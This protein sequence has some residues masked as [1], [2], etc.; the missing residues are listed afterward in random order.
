MK[1]TQHGTDHW[2]FGTFTVLYGHPV[3]PVPDALTPQRKPH[4]RERP[5]LHPPAPGDLWP[6]PRGAPGSTGRV[7]PAHQEADGLRRRPRNGRGTRWCRRGSWGYPAPES[8]V[9]ARP[10]ALACGAEPTGCV[11]TGGRGGR[12]SKRRGERRS[13]R[14]WLTRRQTLGESELGRA[15]RQ[16]APSGE[17]GISGPKAVCRRDFF[18]LRAGQSVLGLR[19]IERGPPTLAR[20]LLYSKS[21]NLSLRLLEKRPYRNIQNN[22]RPNVMAH[23]R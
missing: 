1:G 23:P 19:L 14:T 15:G 8:A 13:L 18:L 3:Y 6:P 21:T 16:A 4:T 10:S 7:S 11:C 22:D 17:S 2:A 5:L 20:N 9:R 12:R